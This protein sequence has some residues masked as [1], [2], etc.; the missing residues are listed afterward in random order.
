M[1]QFL[2]IKERIYYLYIFNRFFFHAR[3]LWC[4]F[5]VETAGCSVYLKEAAS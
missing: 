5:L 1:E 2:E 4:T 3:K